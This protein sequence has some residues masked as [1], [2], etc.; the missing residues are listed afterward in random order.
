MSAKN[1]G[2]VLFTQTD[3]VVNFNPT[4][5]TLG[6]RVGQVFGAVNGTITLNTSFDGSV[7]PPAFKATGNAVVLDTDGDQILFDVVFTGQFSNPPLAPPAPTPP[8]VVAAGSYTAAYT[9]SQATGKY[10]GIQ[11]RTFNGVGAATQPAQ[12]QTTG[13]AFTQ[14][15]GTLNKGQGPPK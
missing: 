7:A 12:T 4:P 8:V 13:S 1:S 9:V 5:G 10:T 11:G 14:I 6:V 2:P 15:F 3:T